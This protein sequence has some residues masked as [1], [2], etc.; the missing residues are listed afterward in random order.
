[1][2]YK[3]T[4]SRFSQIQPDRKLLRRQHFYITLICLN[5]SLFHLNVC[6]V[7]MESIADDIL[8]QIQ[9]EIFELTC[10]QLLQC[11]KNRHNF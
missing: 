5:K 4:L 10:S 7:Y 1:M 9:S 3:S 2:S 11:L 8:S 6:R